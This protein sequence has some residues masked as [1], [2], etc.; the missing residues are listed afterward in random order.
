MYCF[1]VLF[2]LNCLPS[3]N[4]A[5]FDVEAAYAESSP[6][7]P[8]FFVLFPGVDPTQ[9]VEKV[10][11][12]HGVS[13]KNGNFLNISMG[14]GQ[15]KNAEL[16]IDGFSKKGGWIM[17]QNVHLMSTWL[18]A[19]ER[20]LEVASEKAHKDFRCL[21][22]AEPPPMMFPLMKVCLPSTVCPQ[23]FALNCLP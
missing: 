9:E 18:T 8:I 10:A 17:L 6:S 12:A 3:T 20:K 19:L 11:A 5:P 15:E 2:A 1:Y 14:Q 22:S 16:A 7:T 21:I 23:L 4:Q 13:S